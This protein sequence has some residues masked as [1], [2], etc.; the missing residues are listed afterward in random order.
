MVL[1]KKKK[2]WKVYDDDDDNGQRTNFDHAEKLAL[3]FGSG[4]LKCINFKQIVGI[5]KLLEWY[6]IHIQVKI[7]MI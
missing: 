7:S 2:M 4:V 3:A 6:R 1:K 5:F